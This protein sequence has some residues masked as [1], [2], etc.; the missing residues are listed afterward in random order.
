[1]AMV[2]LVVAA[3]IPLAHPVTTP[4]TVVHTAWAHMAAAGDLMLASPLAVTD[5]AILMPVAFSA[6]S[7]FVHY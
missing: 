6:Y 3:V 2:G 5:I 7:F 1:M 4:I